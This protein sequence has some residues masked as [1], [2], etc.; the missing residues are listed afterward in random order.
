MIQ[1]LL[2]FQRAVE[3]LF[4]LYFDKSGYLFQLF[5]GGARWLLWRA[6]EF[7]DILCVGGFTS[8]I[9]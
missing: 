4:N 1:S 2:R 9:R 5:F 6:M 7:I 3:C 8:S